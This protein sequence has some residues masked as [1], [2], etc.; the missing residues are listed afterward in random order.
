VKIMNSE[1][2]R[3]RT[4]RWR[5]F[6]AAA[7]SERLSHPGVVRVLRKDVTREGE[8]FVVMELLRGTP[9]TSIV[10]EAGG[11]LAPELLCYIGI[12]AAGLLAHAHEAGVVLRNVQPGSFF[13]TH[14][15]QLKVMSLSGAWLHDDDAEVATVDEIVGPSPWRA[16]EIDGA[17]GQ[18]GPR[19]ADVFGLGTTLY[20][21]ATGL[22]P[23]QLGDGGRWHE[24]F[25]WDAL[26][27]V[28]PEALASCIRRACS[29]IPAERPPSMEHL[30]DEL[31]RI[32][33]QAS[34]GA[35]AG[36]LR[37]M[38]EWLG[39]A[40][41]RQAS[42]RGSLESI[43][44]RA[45][46]MAT[47]LRDSFRLVEQILHSV[48]RQ[49]WEHGETEIRIQGLVQ[50]VTELLRG[51][52]TTVKWTI[53]PYSFEFKEEAVW[54]PRPPHDEV[55]YRLFDA[56]F[57][58]MS[59]RSG[60][61]EAELREW[62]R[63]L[64][65]EPETEL[66][67]EDDMAT[68]FWNREFPHIEGRLISSIILQDLKDFEVLDRE[69]SELQTDALATLRGTIQQRVA[70]LG[71]AAYRGVRSAVRPEDF[72][73]SA[74][75]PAFAFAEP[76]L[77][78]LRSQLFDRIEVRGDEYLHDLAEAVV[79]A[80]RDARLH[81]DTPRIV[82]HV[83]Q[84]LEDRV[85]AV[86]WR[87]Y[88]DF[89]DG[90]RR[91]DTEGSGIATLA[92]LLTAPA[93]LEVVLRGICSE[94]DADETI[95]MRH[96]LDALDGL[97]GTV[98]ERCF[99]ALLETASHSSLPEA[100]ELL[101]RHVS[102][103]VDGREEKLA[104]MLPEAFP[105]LGVGLVRV[106]ALKPNRPALKALRTA[107]LN[108]A[109]PVRLE[110]LDVRARV[111]PHEVT[112]ELDPLLDDPDARVRVRA[113]EIARHR[114]L[115]GL[116]PRLAQRIKAPSFDETPLVDRHALLTT[117]FAIAPEQ[118][119]SLC[120]DIAGT[121]GLL[122]N[123]AQNVSRKLAV[124]LLAEEGRSQRSLEVARDAAKP[125]WW[126]SKELQESAHVAVEKLTARLAAQ[127]G[128]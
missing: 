63:W 107:Y 58:E 28:A 79:A 18:A 45:W 77:E 121:H 95:P 86:D 59:L 30:R 113:H 111:V 32:V 54:E 37:S 80:L 119:E 72:D 89:F 34:H 73:V 52:G 15:G 68:V 13:V 53:R 44:A 93:R 116:A 42:Q 75:P 99:D 90:L 10:R 55:P 120:I 20:S 83:E 87:G 91:H 117:L 38:G 24:V 19:S 50:T 8:P 65:I 21:L 69:L 82:A 43:D 108:P 101:L 40:A 76:V 17:R 118:A 4:V 124:E 14:T 61:D 100:I 123:T 12:E 94:P 56:G 60:L 103:F 33:D 92:P 112:D 122:E 47:K 115:F 49:G 104:Q 71:G 7:I 1:L 88:L 6:R 35:L 16:P 22:L 126:N 114:R 98:D 64:A 74:R 11:R 96:W 36:S 25:N 66:A 62:L 85:T 2:A 51:E 29:M 57:R 31:S 48:Q 106:L 23:R 84:F 3:E 97:L 27:S 67:D 70:A 127:G 109:A 125:R 105:G 102:R 26:Y 128:A 9:L 46:E 41:A 39:E 5:F 81:G 78:E 110:A